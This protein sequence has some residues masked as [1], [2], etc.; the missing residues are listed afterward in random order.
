MGVDPMN[1][2]LH[3]MLTARMNFRIFLLWVFM[4]A[5]LFCIADALLAVRSA[6]NAVAE[7]VEEHPETVVGKP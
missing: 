1:R 3:K 2:I 6:V 5:V 7:Y 4:A